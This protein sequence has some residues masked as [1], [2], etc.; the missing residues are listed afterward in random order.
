M[1]GA[2][3]QGGPSD[4]F[5]SVPNA[6]ELGI[7]Q[8]LVIEDDPAQRS[9]LV[10]LF[11]AANA[12]NLGMVTFNV[13]MVSCGQEAL[14]ITRVDGQRFH[15]ILLDL[16]LPDIAGQE[17]LPQ[18]RLQVGETSSILIASAH[19]QVALVQLCVRR[20]ADAFLSKP[21]HGAEIQHMWQFAKNLPIDFEDE[22]KPEV[23]C[24]P[25]LD[26]PSCAGRPPGAIANS[27]EPPRGGVRA[28]GPRQAAGGLGVAANETVYLCSGTAPA[29][30]DS[31]DPPSPGPRGI[32]TD[33]LT[34]AC[35]AQRISSHSA[36]PPPN[37]P[38]D[39]QENGRQSPRQESGRQSSRQRAVR[40]GRVRPW[41]HRQPNPPVGADCKQQ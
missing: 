35:A 22:V 26:P 29:P 1:H 3:S 32:D 14:D 25:L 12:K 23:E 28:L 36:E 17:L 40:V 7:L 31:R 6:Q 9:L 13:F 33:G 8:V 16:Q 10:E 21:L 41:V 15:L 24:E 27:S 5:G 39:S 37:A 19:T 30:S 18:L 4:P 38:P 11:E 20:G 2:G 34:D